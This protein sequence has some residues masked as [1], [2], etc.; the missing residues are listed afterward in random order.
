MGSFRGPISKLDS[1][2]F[3][4]EYLVHFLDHD[5]PAIRKAVCLHSLSLFCS[6]SPDF[7]K[8]A[9]ATAKL[10]IQAEA[11]GSKRRST[12]L[13]SE[14]SV[15]MGTVE[16]LLMVGIADPDPSIRETVFKQL[17]RIDTSPALVHYLGN[18]HFSL[19][20]PSLSCDLIN[21]LQRRI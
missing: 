19:S 6:V 10:L 4:N 3:R 18:C 16:K 7:C 9:R 5:S 17:S 11:Q 13:P 21:M 1:E 20:S 12:P 8:A 2:Q 14:L 15:T